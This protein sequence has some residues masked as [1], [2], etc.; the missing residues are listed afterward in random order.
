[1]SQ[2]A[3]VYPEP[4]ILNPDRFLNPDGTFSRRNE[5]PIFGYGKRYVFRDVSTRMQFIKLLHSRCPAANLGNAVVFTA[6]ATMVWS[7]SLA[8]PNGSELPNTDIN[9]WQTKFGFMYA[10]SYYEL[11]IADSIYSVPS[12]I[13]CV[14]TARDASVA[15]LLSDDI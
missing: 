2:D 10:K 1:M 12:D 15:K 3:S 6:M 13:S 11:S 7:L 14:I 5:L 8:T 4:D 9:V